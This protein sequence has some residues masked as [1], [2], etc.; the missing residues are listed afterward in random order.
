MA[1]LNVQGLSTAQID[2]LVAH[3]LYEY[4]WEYI[5]I[6]YSSWGTPLGIP[7]DDLN[8]F[9]E[10]ERVTVA[11]AQL[12][13]DLPNKWVAYRPGG[14]YLYGDTPLEALKKCFCEK[15]LRNMEVPDWVAKL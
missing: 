13:I 15:S 4:T 5:H 1:K 12:E 11:P 6:L 2:V 10:T 9:M 3:L 7:F 14:G 8:E